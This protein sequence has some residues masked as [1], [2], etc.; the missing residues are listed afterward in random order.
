MRQSVKY[1]IKY[2]WVN[3]REGHSKFQ[4]INENN[5]EK[6]GTVLIETSDMNVGDNALI[7]SH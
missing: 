3:I 2:N 1:I 7:N 6:E 4:G 5:N